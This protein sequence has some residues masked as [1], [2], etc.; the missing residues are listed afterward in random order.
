VDGVEVR[1]ESGRG[2]VGVVRVREMGEMRERTRCVCDQCVSERER[3][4]MQ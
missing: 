2:H 3:D 1:R 4:V